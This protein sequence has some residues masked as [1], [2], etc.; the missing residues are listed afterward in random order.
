MTHHC[1]HTAHCPPS[2]YFVLPWLIKLHIE[3]TL[4]RGKRHSTSP[5]SHL[6]TTV[7]TNTHT[8]AWFEAQ[9]NVSQH[10]GTYVTRS[11]T[12]TNQHIKFAIDAADIW[13]STAVC[14]VHYQSKR[15][16]RLSLLTASTKQLSAAIYPTGSRACSVYRLT[17]PAL[18]D[19]L[20]L[21][22]RFRNQKNGALDRN[23]P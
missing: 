14:C 22:V 11:G 12:S 1:K 3:R 2:V 18:T 15:G 5:R 10:G 7:S 16:F 6:S 19:T 13:C 9:F 8:H 21:K 20:N 4:V 17:A 23:S